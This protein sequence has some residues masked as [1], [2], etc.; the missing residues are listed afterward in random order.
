MPSSVKRL[1]VNQL[2]REIAEAYAELMRDV[3]LRELDAILRPLYEETV[4][5][6]NSSGD[7][8]HP[9]PIFQIRVVRLPTP[10]IGGFD[11]EFFSQM[12]ESPG[13]R[14]THMLWATLDFGSR[15]YTKYSPWIRRRKKYRTRGSGLADQAF[16]GYD[17]GFFRFA[18]GDVFEGNDY[19]KKIARIIEQTPIHPGFKLT[20][21]IEGEINA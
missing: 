18:P 7:N 11:M 21:N 20:L 5:Y 8:E 14:D 19:S 1:N 2:K 3:L 12:V 4:Q 10:D 17:Q 9:K 15:P 13:D 6:W 16:A